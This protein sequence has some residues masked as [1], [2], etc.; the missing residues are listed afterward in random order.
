MHLLGKQHQ[1]HMSM[2]NSVP[3]FDAPESLEWTG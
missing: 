3:T 2:K 1:A